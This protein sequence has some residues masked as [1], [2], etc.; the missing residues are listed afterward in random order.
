VL[1]VNSIDTEIHL[2]EK[3]TIKPCVKYIA[4]MLLTNKSVFAQKF[5]NNGTSLLEGFNKLKII[6][7]NNKSF[8][9]KKKFYEDMSI[10][11]MK[12]NMIKYEPDKYMTKDNTNFYYTTEGKYYHPGLK[13]MIDPSNELEAIFHYKY[14]YMREFFCIRNIT[15][16][17]Y[18]ELKRDSLLLDAY[19]RGKESLESSLS[20]KLSQFQK[21]NHTISH[22]VTQ[23]VVHVVTSQSL[24]GVRYVYGNLLALVKL[25]CFTTVWYNYTECAPD[26]LSSGMLPDQFVDFFKDVSDVPGSEDLLLLDTKDDTTQS[27]VESG[28]LL[29]DTM[30]IVGEEL[31]EG[32]PDEDIPIEDSNWISVGVPVCIICIFVVT[33]TYFMK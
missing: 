8:Q 6:Q 22:K 3:T 25:G 32:L 29:K 16:L 27:I 12:E 23:C 7:S 28:K 26:F 19:K 33:V 9:Q 5:N 24:S 4:I 15:P 11:K 17:N 2:N 18:S 14:S 21:I 1:A 13:H 30:L 31:A 10:E 20:Y